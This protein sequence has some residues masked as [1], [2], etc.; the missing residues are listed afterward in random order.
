MT[1]DHWN[2]YLYRCT[3]RLAIMCGNAEP[4]EEQMK[5]ARD[6]AEQAVK[7]LNE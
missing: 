3:E 7:E 1:P 5:I 6:E 4:T 2:E